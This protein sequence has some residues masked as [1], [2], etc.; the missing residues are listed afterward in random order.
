M[1]VC[2]LLATMKMRDGAK[3]AGEEKDKMNARV[4]RNAEYERFKIR[5]DA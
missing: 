4:D 5:T 3:V 1:E 2:K